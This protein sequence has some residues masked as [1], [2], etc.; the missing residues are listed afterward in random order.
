MVVMLA[1]FLMMA[2]TKKAENLHFLAK[3]LRIAGDIFGKSFEKVFFWKEKMEKAGFINVKETVKKVCPSY[4]C[5][6][7]NL[8]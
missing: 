4:F 3:N 2:L 7:S 6:Y 8:F 1:I 5:S